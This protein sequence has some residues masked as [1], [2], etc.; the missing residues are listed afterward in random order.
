M[1]MPLDLKQYSL[2]E[3]EKIDLMLKEWYR[4]RLYD[5]MFLEEIARDVLE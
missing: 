1:S 2:I 4:T 3:P 5:P